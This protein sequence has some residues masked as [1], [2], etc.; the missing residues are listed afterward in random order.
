MHFSHEA[1]LRHMRYGLKWF[2]PQPSSVLRSPRSIDPS[3]IPSRPQQLD[4]RVSRCSQICE[5]RV[6]SQGAGPPDCP[7]A[8]CAADG[9]EP[10]AEAA[11]A[12]H[13]GGPCRR[14]GPNPAAAA[15]H[16]VPGV[17]SLQPKSR[18]RTFESLHY[19]TLFSLTPS[20]GTVMHMYPT[21]IFPALF[22]DS[23]P[24]PLRIV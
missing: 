20:L 12:R 21:H 11:A 3:A 9:A 18:G 22:D 2:R 14:R 10:G 13:E 4:S 7:G 15:G 16:S 8:L 1:A 6:V 17:P 24:S 19:S 23:T 5:R